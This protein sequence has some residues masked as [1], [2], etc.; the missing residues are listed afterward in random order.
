MNRH[1]SA[2]TKSA[3]GPPEAFAM[4][5]ISATLEGHLSDG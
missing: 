5:L 2:K 1:A 4:L 3:M